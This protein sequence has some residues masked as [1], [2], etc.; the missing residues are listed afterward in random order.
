[1]FA[2]AGT[3]LL[4]CILLCV[5]TTRKNDGVTL[6]LTIGVSTLTGWIVIFLSHAVY[7]EAKAT[8]RHMEAMQEG[9]RETF[10]GH[11]EKSADFYRIRRGVTVRHVHA[12]IGERDMMLNVAEALS[13]DVPDAFS[14]TVETVHGFLVA[15]E[16]SAD[17]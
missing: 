10:T 7:D 3:G 9:E 4:I 14:G 16:V 1:M 6:P 8:V 11:F 12:R 13:K 15:Y 2:I 17:D 5:F